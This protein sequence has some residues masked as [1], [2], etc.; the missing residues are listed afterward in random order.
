MP[1]PDPIVLSYGFGAAK[2]LSEISLGA[3]SGSSGGLVNVKFSEGR[4]KE[5][6]SSGTGGGAEIIPGL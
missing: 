4:A 5:T 6:T 2:A 1:R 3:P